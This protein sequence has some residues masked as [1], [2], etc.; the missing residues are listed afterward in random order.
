[1]HPMALLN[2]L[3]LDGLAAST[4]RSALPDA[5]VQPYRGRSHRLARFAAM[6]RA[7]VAH[8]PAGR[9]STATRVRPVTRFAGLNVRNHGRIGACPE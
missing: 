8:R 2:E 3:H 5:P 9:R 6:I 7:S 4:T 1:M